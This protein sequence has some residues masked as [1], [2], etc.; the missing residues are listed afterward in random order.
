MNAEQIASPVQNRKAIL[1]KQVR[2]LHLYFGVFFAPAIIFFC[3]TGAL[4]LFGLH[5]GH[6]GEAYQPPKWVAALA[7]VHKDQVLSQHHGPPP[8]SGAGK[9]QEL[10][11]RLPQ[12]EQRHEAAATRILK[13]FFLA[14]SIGLVATTGLGIYMAFAYNRDRRVVWGLLLAGIVVPAA[15]IASLA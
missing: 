1:L 5:E 15:L 9:Q 3:F 4:Q 14:M 10:P 7:A 13:C 6:P 2:R 12:R 8:D 11:R